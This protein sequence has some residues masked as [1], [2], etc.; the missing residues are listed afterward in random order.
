MNNSYI[1]IICNEWHNSQQFK[2]NCII[3]IYENWFGKFYEWE[4]ISKCIGKEAFSSFFFLILDIVL[5]FSWLAVGSR[6]VV[7]FIPIVSIPVGFIKPLITLVFIK[8][9]NS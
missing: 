9:N 6:K 4:K 1:S 5:H 8:S 2:I 3:E 7:S